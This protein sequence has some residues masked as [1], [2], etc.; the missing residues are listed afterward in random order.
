MF[1][2][3]SSRY[4]LPLYVYVHLVPVFSR[5]FLQS[6]VPYFAGLQGQ[7]CDRSGL[8]EPAGNCSVGYYCP[9]G[10]IY[11]APSDKMCQP[12]HYC[13]L[14]SYKHNVCPPGTYQPYAGRGFCLD[15]SNG[16]Y[17]DPVEA[18]GKR[19]IYCQSK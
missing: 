12:G 2:Y 3:L 16:Y 17:C 1:H 8:A 6:F 15:C 4:T 9:S 10:E 7:Y 19:D 13:P 11:P 14:A 5:A 18:Q